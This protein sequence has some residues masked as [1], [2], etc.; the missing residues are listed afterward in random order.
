MKILIVSS[1]VS[2]DFS[3]ST[4]VNELAAEFARQGHDVLLY[5]QDWDN[6]LD[7][8]CSFTERRVRVL[9]QRH[10]GNIFP[11]PKLRLLLKWSLTSIIG[12]WNHGQEMRRYG[13]DMLIV[14]NCGTIHASQILLL[15]NARTARKLF[16]QW[17]F[18]PIH[19]WEIGM[20]R[21]RALFRISRWIEESLIKR[22]TWIGHMSPRNISFFRENYPRCAELDQLIIPIWGIEPLPA[23]A[24]DERKKTRAAYGLPSDKI[25]AVFGGQLSRGRGL[26]N[27]L[28]LAKRA[29]AEMSSVHFVIIGQ[30]K[31]KDWLA[32]QVESGIHANV[33][34]MD[35][36]AKDRYQSFLASC[37][38]GIVSTEGGTS[39]PSFPSKS[40]DYMRNGLPM[41]ISTEA[42]SD[43]PQIMESA[44]AGLASVAGDHEMLWS[45]LK[46]LAGSEAFRREAGEAGKQHFIANHH[47]ASVVK[48]I[49]AGSTPSPARS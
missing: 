19:H 21:G 47:V 38:I 17:D 2:N 11:I 29:Q 40:I 22:F 9:W 25:I 41:L 44:G 31:L 46:K 7:K 16:I 45:N 18:F 1:W 20:F 27:I 3:D 6:R 30:G 37:D 13:A 5:A 49:I 36:I 8:T 28:A 14:I 10:A 42:S 43:F 34:L 4:L 33:T 12:W 48:S 32:R 23:L 15:P 39:V 26:D 35:R 24:P